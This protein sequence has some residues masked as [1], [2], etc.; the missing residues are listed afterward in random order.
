MLKALVKPRMR[1]GAA[2]RK[3]D[4]T[5]AADMTLPVGKH[6]GAIGRRRRGIGSAGAQHAAG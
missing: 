6:S 2:L 3:G 4:L 5:R 1:R